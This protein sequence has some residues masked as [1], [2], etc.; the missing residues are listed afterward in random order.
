M[1]LTI[2]VPCYNAEETLAD[3]LDALAVQEWSEPWETIIVNNGSTDSSR[4]I[5]WQY[6][7]KIPNYRVVDA[8]ERQGQPYALNRGVEEALGDS[9]AFA[10]ADD[11]IGT[12]WVAAMG[13]ALQTHDFVACRIELEKLNK[14]EWIM[15]RGHT[16]VNGLQKIWYPPYFLHA[17]GGTLGV[18]RHLHQAVDGFDENFPILHDTDFCF[19]VQMM[20][21]KLHFVP[22]AVMHVRYRN[23]MGGVY[24][25]SRGYAR[26]NVLL[27]KK[28]RNSAQLVFNPWA[29]YM[30]DWYKLVKYMLKAK[31]PSGRAKL[32]WQL[33]RQMGR[34]EGVV[35]YHSKPV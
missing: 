9:V 10:D 28:Y 21:I 13:S 1:K 4:E 30:Q 16:Q 3:Q 2:I 20:G 5:A 7:G 23:S 12:S 15:G 25:Q 19:K 22:D 8:F 24:R 26:Y 32:V 34:L 29:Q 17:G 31:N 35:K 18:K 27:A 14:P 33:G 11:Q 6:E